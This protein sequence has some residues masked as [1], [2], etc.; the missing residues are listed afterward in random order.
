MLFSS[1]S[2]IYYF[3]PISM[4]FYLLTPKRFKNIT[5]LLVSLLFYFLGE[6]VY[7]LLLVFSSVSD[8]LHSLYIEKHRGEKKAKYALISSIVINLGALGFF[9]YIDFFITIINQILKV[10]IP[11]LG[12]PLPIG[13]SFFTFQT[14]SYTIDVYRGEVKAERSFLSLATFVCLFPQLIAGPIVR[15]SDIASE[16]KHRVTDLSKTAEGV[17]RFVIGLS[18]KV[19]LANGFGEFC[20]LYRG[21]EQ[22]SVLFHW[23]YAIAFTMQIYFDFS[24]YS[25]MA[26]GMGKMLGFTFPENFNYPY[27]SKSI[28]EFWR[29]W[30]MS[31]SKWFRDYVYIPLGGNRVTKVKWI[32]NIMTVWLLTGLWHGA[33]LN[34]VVW[35]GFFGT[36]LL[37]EK[38][39]YGRQL[40]RLPA[41]VKHI[42]VMFLVTVSFV[43]FNADTMRIAMSDLAGMFGISD[44]QYGL[45]LI[46][47]E[48]L[49]YFKSY[50]LLFVFGF[51][52][53]TPLVKNVVLQFKALSGKTSKSTTLAFSGFLSLFM[54]ES[55]G[56]IVL[57]LIST[58]NLISGS[59]NPFLYFRF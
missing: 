58:A 49:Y 26:I 18:K 19:L 52:G 14:M 53:A 37:L 33:A 11:V 20:I 39:I 9:K 21:A 47:N 55:V 56:S 59:F 25:D 35:G 3:L 6:P 1:I 38:F 8:Y 27:V 17:Q 34:F 16:L 30:H 13:I 22:P 28:T 45:P 46:T 12:V 7:T 40:E 31:L 36:L 50:G 10:Q 51:V 29:R 23:M 41:I 2:F 57:L 5:L 4:A 42:Y 32:R 48:S 24:G 15:Y 54:I 43:I 44:L